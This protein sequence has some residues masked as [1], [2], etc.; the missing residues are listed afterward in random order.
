[1]NL[2][3][4]PI[5]NKNRQEALALKLAPYQK[6]YV[7]TIEEC[8]KE[9]DHKKC[10]RPVGIY[11]GDTLVGFAMYGFFW[12]YFPFGRVWLDRFSY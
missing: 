4:E 11:D 6:G 12:M 8:L 9:A 2:H 1:M 3:I 5:T 7:E 10:W